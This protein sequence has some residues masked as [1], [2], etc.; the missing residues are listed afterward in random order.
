MAR[1]CAGRRAATAAR[2]ELEIDGRREAALHPVGLTYNVNVKYL[3]VKILFAKV[4]FPD[5][6][7]STSLPSPR[8]F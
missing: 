7:G 3:N 8:P 6:T 1:V 4:Q 5:C 2:V